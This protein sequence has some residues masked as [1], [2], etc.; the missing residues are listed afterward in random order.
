[1]KPSLE[2]LIEEAGLDDE[3]KI[4]ELLLLAL[5]DNSGLHLPLEATQKNVDNFYSLEVRPALINGDPAYI[6]HSSSGTRSPIAFTCCSTCVN[7]VYDLEKKIAIGVITVIAKPF[8]NQGIATK[9]HK[10]VLSDLKKNG[11]ELVL[12]E[13]SLSNKPSFNSCLNIVRKEG[14]EYNIIANKYE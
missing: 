12:T 9:L 3:K 14:L 11:T 5:E 2:N 10:R 6:A 1:M 8:R 13:I 7:K 4:K